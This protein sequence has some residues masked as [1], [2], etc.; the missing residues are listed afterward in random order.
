MP[1]SYVE[2]YDSMLQFAQSIIAYEKDS[3]I[4]RAVFVKTLMVV[5]DEFNSVEE[6][7]TFYSDIKFMVDHYVDSAQSQGD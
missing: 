7:K 4:W 2:V 1:K 6:S 5:L 3:P